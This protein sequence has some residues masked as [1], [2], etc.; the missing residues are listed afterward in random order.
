[1]REK[2]L[3]QLIKQ[4]AKDGVTELDLSRKGL[5]ALPPEIVQL[6]NLQSLALSFNSLTALP[7]E[8]VQ[9]TNLQ[10]LALRNN[11]LTALPPEIGQLTN[12]QSLDLS[13][14]SLTALPPEI[15]QLTN[16]QSLALSGTSL[17]ALPPEIV[18]LT[19]LQSLDL[20][21][22]SL[23]A[24]PP[25]IGQLTNLQ[26]L[27]LFGTSL[28]ALP[29]EIGQLT[30]LQSLALSF[31]SLTALPPEIGQLTNLQSLALRNN[32][33]TALPPE[34]VQLTN[35]QSLDLRNNSL[36]ALPPEI[37]QLTNLQSLDLSGTSL[38]ALPPEIVQLTN[39][40]S[41][42]LMNNSLTA[43]PPE[44]GQLTNLQS[45][46]LSFNSLTA[47][48]PEIVQLTNLQSLVLS[49]NSLTALPPEI[50][51]LTNLQ[52]LDLSGNSLTALP[53]E[54]VQLTNLQSLALM[55]NS[56]TALPP[57]I[58]QLKNLRGLNLSG[59][60]LSIPPEILEQ[61]EPATIINFYLQHLTGE[62]KPLNEAKVLLVGQGS[63]GK[64]SLVRR[65]V[66]G[67]FDPHETKT[68]GINIRRW[69]ASVNGQDI[70]LNVWDF[71]GQEIMHATHQFFLT[72]RSLY[73]LVLDARLGEEEN[74]LEYWLK[75]IQSFGGDSPVVVV[76]NKIDQHPLDIDKRGLRA[77]Y[78]AIRAIVE[79]SCV[80]GA[81][82]EE[83]G[84][85]IARE[86]GALPHVY[87]PLLLTWFAVKTRLETMEQDY[88]PYTEYLRLCQEENITDE[89]SP[90]TLIG[91]L[92]DLGAVLNFR[93]DPRLEDTNI[94]NPEWVTDGVYR[95]LTAKGLFESQGVL[96][97]A[98][99]NRILDCPA[100]PR[101]KHLFIMDMMRKFELCFDLEGFRDQLFLIP[102]LLPKEE[103][104]TGDWD[105]AL[106][107]QYQ[108][109]VLPSN[110]ISRFI[111]RAH[112]LIHQN[113]YWRAGVV[114]AYEGNAALV[115]ADKEDRKI[116]I[117]IHGPERTRRTFLAIIRS[118]FDHIHQTIPGIQAQGKV[119]LP[120]H[121]E[122][123]VDYAHLLKLEEKG[124]E[125]FY[126][127]GLDEIREYNVRQL[128]DGVDGT[129]HERLIHLH[130][131]LAERF[132]EGELRTLCFELDVRYDQ[133]AGEEQSSKAR[134]LV[135]F[136]A[137][138]R[139][140]PE[141]IRVGRKTRP[142]V[143]WHARL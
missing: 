86:V 45:L 127:Q 13:G 18:Q 142:D 81:G 139:R 70:R 126:P 53:P 66:E 25:E 26:S 29:P 92:H 116:F 90:R 33:L 76:G 78:P 43:L 118:Q 60:S 30:N 37:V 44:I 59:N 141:L 122:V 41:L 135:E 136:L 17:T 108:Y 87:D 93:D 102:D 134:E 120:D 65:L 67:A 19:N 3:L 94:L 85:T 14:T 21:G 143:P 15:G 34:I 71:G 96:D 54:I 77:K 133:L 72:R 36:T 140:I 79:T 83:L 95:I 47:L 55:N 131:L 27:D 58:V 82:V 28:T 101:R 69:G 89:Y 24:L 128:L 113:T 91:F 132:S 42:A 124:V 52:S 38:T 39:L 97:R 4:A 105:G 104:D 20:S 35:L 123:V 6:T 100:Y 16:L 10:S 80:T 61:G 129:T 115:K 130:R 57:E 50:V 103:P 109:D 1:M 99:L 107:F 119:P 46:A 12:L 98:A 68:E 40:Q 2:E 138:R 32:S 64:T 63:V 112:T 110:I 22:T 11:S 117:Q 31:N 84:A 56:L 23:T 62:K 106:A 8:I 114:L 74:R 73:L 9:L 7:P 111:V 51:Q 75:I 121:P 49:G 48:P 88:I 137:R 5:N 125:S